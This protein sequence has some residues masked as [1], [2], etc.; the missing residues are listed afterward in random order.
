[1]NIVLN[2][3]RKSF[4]INKYAYTVVFYHIPKTAGLSVNEIML[5]N[6]NHHYNCKFFD[7][8]HVPHSTRIYK[9]P[10]TNKSVACG[11]HWSINHS[12]L[13]KN[14]CIVFSLFRDPIE[15]LISH[16]NFIIKS[17][18]KKTGFPPV[19]INKF[20][21][22]NEFWDDK[23]LESKIGIEWKQEWQR[24]SFDHPQ[25][26]YCKS[27]SLG[28]NNIQDEEMFNNA[29][30]VIDNNEIFVFDPIFNHP[31]NYKKHMF[32]FGIT[33]MFDQ[34]MKF[35][36]NL[37]NWP[38]NINNIYE[39]VNKNKSKILSDLSIKN[40]I[41]HNKLDIYI[42]NMSLKKFKQQSKFIV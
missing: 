7:L 15:R 35:L 27:L 9:D 42:Y 18:I 19:S 2:K 11:G 26:I 40:L 10:S 29:K 3:I 14:K 32:F 38:S 4:L 8:G 37:F 6:Y 20:L 39:N 33:E 24:N 30:S 17:I 1:M 31:N 23:K 41:K 36:K 16:Y 34:S 12:L 5:N 22:S 21:E 28:D 13:T 25:N